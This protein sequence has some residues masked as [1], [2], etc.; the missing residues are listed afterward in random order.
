MAATQLTILPGEFRL[1]IEENESILHAIRRAGL[2]SFVEAPCNGKHTCGKCRIVVRGGAVSPPTAKE[3]SLLTA[4]ELAQGIRLACLTQASA[5]LSPVLVETAT[6]NMQHILG[7]G[8]MPSFILAPRLKKRRYTFERQESEAGGIPSDSLFGRVEQAA[9][10]AL[11]TND[12]HLLRQLAD[13]GIDQ[14]FDIVYFDDKPIALETACGSEKLLGIAVDIGTTTVACTLLD[15]ESGTQ[16]GLASAI[17]PQTA[18][19]ADVLSRI[20]HT[21]QAPDGLAELQTLIV[22]CLNSLSQELLDQGYKSESVY[23]YAVAANTT[24][25]HLLLGVPPRSIALAPY[26]PVFT[27][28]QLI[29]ARQFGLKCCAPSAVL[30]CLPSVSGYIG[31]DILAGIHIAGLAD[32]PD[33]VL[34]IDIGTNGEIVLSRR[35]TLSSCSCAAGPALE[36]M[37]ISCGMRAAA[38]AIEKVRFQNGRFDIETIGN[39]PPV[40]LCGSGV[41]EVISTL[42]QEGAIDKSGRIADPLPDMFKACTT[43]NGRSYS[44]ILHG[45]DTPVHFTQAD[46]RQVQL[47]KGAI[48]SGITALLGSAGLAPS[49]VD[50]VM[51]AGQFGAHLTEDSLLGS[52]LLPKEFQGK[53]SY[54]GNTSLSGAELFLLDNTAGVIMKRLSQDISY[55]ELAT[56][57]NYARL[58]M[59]SMAFG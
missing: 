34:F 56:Y 46:I 53:I 29:P 54:L 59:T 17:N 14:D 19:G 37:N 40:G 32:A 20:E 49:D 6:S 35:G 3:L 48:L 41:L 13:I 18:F 36:G 50:R 11:P 16:L 55:L 7:E 58:L 25:L 1:E 43:P 10:A 28:A 4:E 24:M 5:P 45:S 15:L 2:H 30:C 23:C 52:G 12:V 33:T 22:S 8:F 21:M 47:A 9:G 27:G 38:G 31:A 42:V 51:I 44:F 57:P 39:L 26:Y